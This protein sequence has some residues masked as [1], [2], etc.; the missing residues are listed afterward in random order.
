MLKKDEE[1]FDFGCN[2][3]SNYS[4]TGDDHDEHDGKCKK[5]VKKFISCSTLT[6]CFSLNGE[7]DTF[8]VPREIVNLTFHP[9]PPSSTGVLVKLCQMHHTQ[10]KSMSHF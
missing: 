7:I 6:P 1:G 9:L 2:P 5:I 4:K 3:T 8:C 10:I